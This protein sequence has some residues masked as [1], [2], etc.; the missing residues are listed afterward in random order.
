MAITRI[1]QQQ[2]LR[3][4]RNLS[5]G[6]DTEIEDL[7]VG[8][9][10]EVTGDLEVGADAEVGNDLAVG[11]DIDLTGDLNAGANVQVVGDG[12]VDGNLDVG[13]D[14]SVIGEGS[15]D[16]DLSVGGDLNLTGDLP[17]GSASNIETLHSEVEAAL[18]PTLDPDTITVVHDGDPVGSGGTLLR[19]M[20]IPVG[21]QVWLGGDGAVGYVAATA[22]SLEVFPTFD[23][24]GAPQVYHRDSGAT[25]EGELAADLRQFGYA[26]G[27]MAYAESRDGRQLPIRSMEDPD[28][29]G[30][31][32]Y[33]V[34]NGLIANLASYSDTDQTV[35]L[36]LTHRVFPSEIPFIT[37]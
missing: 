22:P 23:N 15:V 8:G 34:G 3:V 11:N 1:N 36:S 17:I 25:H 2:D 5:V 26:D 4:A 31:A 28:T 33:Y 27:T 24:D 18:A 6:G 35:A 10:L 37:S 16:L 30:T 29:N 20:P 21:R 7:N 13:G 14:L 12:Q 9:D 32:V 19:A